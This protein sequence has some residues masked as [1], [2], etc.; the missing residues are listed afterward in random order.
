M[1]ARDLPLPDYDSL[2]TGAIESRARTL[3]AAGVRAL[4]DYEKEHA[5]RVQVVLVLQHRLDSLERGDS[6]PS[7]GDPAALAPEA[8]GAPTHTEPASPQTEGPPINP[9][10]QGDPTNPAQPRR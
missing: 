10:S 9:P 7:G 1:T 8:G 3:D 4:L 6:Q 5:D 2:P